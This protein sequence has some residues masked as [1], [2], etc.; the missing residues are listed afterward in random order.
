MNDGARIEQVREI[1]DPR[2][3][4][5]IAAGITVLTGTIL[6]V[7]AWVASS[8]NDTRDSVR[9][10]VEQNKYVLAQLSTNEVHDSKQ[11]DRAERQEDHINAVDRRLIVVE[12]VTG[13]QLRGGPRSGK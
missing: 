13:V 12:Q 8:I 9:S 6:A 11:D 5:I 3:T 10:L 7:G 2:L 4:A 1:R